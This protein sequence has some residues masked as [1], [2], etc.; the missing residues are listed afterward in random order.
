MSLQGLDFRFVAETVTAPT[1]WCF[2]EP[3]HVFVVHRRGDLKSMEIDFESGPSG[4]CLPRIGDVWVIPAEHRYA[5][6]AQGAMVGFCEIIVPTTKLGEQDLLP[7]VGYQ[8]T[9]LH[10]L[11]ERLAG[12]ANQDG[13][14]ATLFRQSLAETLQFH[15][16]DQYGAQPKPQHLGGSGRQLD[17]LNQQVVIDYLETEL[18][19][20]IDLDVL[21]QAVGMSTSSFLSAFSAAFGTTPHQ[22]LIEQRIRRAKT[23]LTGTT[24]SV[25]EI[26][27]AVGFS[28]PSHFATTFKQRV[29]VS[30]TTY[31][32][33]V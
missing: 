21:A 5:A 20:R 9:L 31:R 17:R 8:D 3:H 1:D 29:G 23:L 33:S 7:R 16:A 18:D 32:N 4:R 26:S 14:A 15:I 22:Y 27:A 13:A 19:S 25:T 11:V 10:R 24:A 12:Q 6:L 2:Q 30:P 28:T